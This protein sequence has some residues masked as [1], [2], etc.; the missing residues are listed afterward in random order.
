MASSSSL[1]E[2]MKD[3]VRKEVSRILGNT[4]SNTTSD[5]RSGA[6]ESPTVVPSALSSNYSSTISFKEFYHMQEE[7]RRGRFKPQPK[8]NKKNPATTTTTAPKKAIDMEIKVGIA[9]QTDGV[10]KS[11]RGKT[12]TVTV[13]STTNKEDIIRRATEKHTSFDQSFD[14]TISY[15]LLYPD[16][17]SEFCT[18]HKELIHAVLLQRS[19]WQ[20]LQA[21]DV[22]PD[23]LSRFCRKLRRYQQ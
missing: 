14:D 16:F 12:H 6:A 5:S 8:K 15:V 2:E 11:R 20:R 7:E 22:L 9:A 19:Y 21:T 10:L 23:P 3:K 18:W 17:R 13:K 1:K 4:I